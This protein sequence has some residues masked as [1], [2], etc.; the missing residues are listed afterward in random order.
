MLGVDRELMLRC[1]PVPFVIHL[2]AEF[3]RRLGSPIQLEK[4]HHGHK[5]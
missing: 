3:S 1:S 4:D 2:A 5:S